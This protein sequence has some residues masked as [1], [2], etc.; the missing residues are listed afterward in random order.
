M[1]DFP[2]PYDDFHVVKK[3]LR[4][5]PLEECISRDENH[6]GALYFLEILLLDVIGN[7]Q[8]LTSNVTFYNLLHFE[9][10]PVNIIANNRSEEVF[11]SYAFQLNDLRRKLSSM[12]HNDEGRGKQKIVATVE[13][14]R[15]ICQEIDTKFRHDNEVRRKEVDSSFERVKTLS[16]INQKFHC[17]ER[18]PV[19]KGKE[20]FIPSTV[21]IAYPNNGMGSWQKTLRNNY[22]L[23][24]RPEGIREELLEG[25]TFALASL[26]SC[27]GAKDADE[28]REARSWEELDNTKDIILDKPATETFFT[29]LFRVN[30]SAQSSFLILEQIRDREDAAT[31]FMSSSPYIKVRRSQQSGD[32]CQRRSE[33]QTIFV[34]LVAIMEERPLIIE[35]ETSRKDWTWYSYALRVP[36]YTTLANHSFWYYFHEL[37]LENDWTPLTGGV[38]RARRLAEKFDAEF[39]QVQADKEV[40]ERFVFDN[41]P[42]E[43]NE[44]NLKNLFKDTKGLLGELLGEVYLQNKYDAKIETWHKEVN[45]TDIDILA[46]TGDQTFLLQAK[47]S[48]SPGQT[49]EV[50]NHFKR[51]E[52]TNETSTKILF[53]LE[54]CPI[55]DQAK[56]DNHSTEEGEIQESLTKI[57]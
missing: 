34:G 26:Y 55:T 42:R 3:L 32:I 22:D 7:V 4:R 2:H 43:R 29:S 52:K 23:R 50:V 46:E 10:D 37:G 31:A 39:Y 33:F 18:R 11:I 54:P 38:D 17:M 51:L 57:A 6:R 13:S 8:D 16:Y 28:L 12:R 49:E 36:G 56:K 44:K 9:G 21:E 45:N 53:L 20:S 1:N 41:S 15:D 35:Y 48:F 30:E 25:Y 47:S 40:L 24:N 14:A 5:F 19:Y 27:F